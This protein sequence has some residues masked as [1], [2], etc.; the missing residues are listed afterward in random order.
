M[1]KVVGVT[2]GIGGG[3]SLFVEAL[4]S[5][6]AH[7]I[8]AD[9]VART[10]MDPTNEAYI[11]VVERFG[12][13]ILTPEK[14]I[15]RKALADIVFQSDMLR[16]ALNNIVHPLVIGKINAA[17]ELFRNQHCADN[18]LMVIE[19]PLLFECNMA[20]IFDVTVAIVS[21]E[22]TRIDR[23]MRLRGLTADQASDRMSA[24]LSDT[25]KCARADVVVQNDGSVEELREK[26]YNFFQT[27]HFPL[28]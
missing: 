9:E 26:A 5:F 27:I 2:G 24:Q 15:D 12:S 6:G 16:E 19:V 28:P 18:S 3:K 1:C 13:K 10:L 20:N 22:R 11:Q 14:K 8:S 17:I 4:A 21:E 25:E 7:T 23:L